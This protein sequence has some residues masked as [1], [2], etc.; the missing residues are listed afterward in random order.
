MPSCPTVRL[1]VMGPSPLRSMAFHMIW[2]GSRERTGEPYFSPSLI[3]RQTTSTLTPLGLW[4]LARPGT[5]QTRYI[6]VL[7]GCMQAVE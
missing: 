7:R 3:I 1:F 4:P 6:Y 2:A 5:L